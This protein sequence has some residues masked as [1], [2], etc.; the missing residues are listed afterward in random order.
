MKL[1]QRRRQLACNVDCQLLP[2]TSFSSVTSRAFHENENARRADAGDDSPRATRVN[3][4][5]SVEGQRHARILE[6]PGWHIK[7][8]IYGVRRGKSFRCV[9]ETFSNPKRREAS[10]GKPGRKI[11]KWNVDREWLRQ[12][13]VNEGCERER[14]RMWE[15]ERAFSVIVKSILTCTYV[16]VSFRVRHIARP[17]ERMPSMQVDIFAETQRTIRWYTWPETRWRREGEAVD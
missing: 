5:N 7:R 10:K 17:R 9:R 2:V 4:S 3:N 12:E 13:I 8:I 6:R 16:Y 14:K 1:T 11:K 15:R